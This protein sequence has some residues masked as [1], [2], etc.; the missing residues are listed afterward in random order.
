MEVDT[1]NAGLTPECAMCRGPTSVVFPA[2]E[3]QAKFWRAV[4]SLLNRLEEKIVQDA[5]QHWSKKVRKLPH[6][7]LI[8]FSVCALVSIV[9][10]LS[11]GAIE[12]DC[13]NCG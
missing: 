10:T 3:P 4:C 5:R 9:C 13:T 6:G 8:R 11:H 7:V 12:R 2:G 1:T